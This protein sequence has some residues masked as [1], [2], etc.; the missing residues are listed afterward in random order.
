MIGASDAKAKKEKINSTTIDRVNSSKPS[1]SDRTLHVDKDLL[2]TPSGQMLQKLKDLRASIN[3]NISGD[4]PVPAPAQDNRKA[5]VKE[6]MRARAEKKPVVSAPPVERAPARAFPA[7]TVRHTRKSH[8]V[9]VAQISPNAHDD[10]DVSVMSDAS[11][12]DSPRED[13][14]VASFSIGDYV[15]RF[16]KYFTRQL[17][18]QNYG[19]RG[20]APV[21]N[22]C[23]IDELLS[24]LSKDT[25]VALLVCVEGS[26][27][28]RSYR[29]VCS[30]E[31][32]FHRRSFMSCGVT[33]STIITGIA[34]LLSAWPPL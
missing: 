33:S 22:K 16:Q 20:A 30:C 24:G 4:G 26:W 27:L 1:E 15:L 12:M 3:S 11:E 28:L 18:H 31:F 23:G 17:S 34:P 32:T 21:P 13:E 6:D 2:K 9:H 7:D 5:S 10:D 29:V 8:P 25:E 19:D 14:S